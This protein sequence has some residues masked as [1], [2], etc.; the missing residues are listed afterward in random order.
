[1]M[2]DSFMNTL[3][4]DEMMEITLA[5]NYKV[6]IDFLEREIGLSP[7]IVGASTM[8]TAIK[9]AMEASGTGNGG[10]YMNVLR[11]SEK[12]RDR[13]I[14][15]LVVPETWFFRGRES[16]K[17][18]VDYAQKKWLAC[19]K[20]GKFR[21]LSFPCSTGEEA[22]TIAMMLMEKGFLPRNFTIDAMDISEKALEKAKTGI[23]SGASF[24]GK[25]QWFMDPYFE[26]TPEGFKVIKKLQKSVRFSKKNILNS[27]TFPRSDL[28][29]AVFCRNLIIYMT[30]E[31]RKRSVDL[32]EQVLRQDGVVFFGHSESSAFKRAGFEKILEPKVFACRKIS[33]TRKTTAPEKNKF[34]TLNIPDLTISKRRE[35]G[36]LNTKTVPASRPTVPPAAFQSLQPLKVIDRPVP[37][38]IPTGE[39]VNDDL[40]EVA[41]HLADQGQF[42]KAHNLCSRF[43][44]KTPLSASAYFL[45]G[46][47][48]QALNR[49]VE[50][51]NCFQKAVYLDPFHALALE[52]LASLKESRD[53][54]AEAAQLRVR[55][56]RARALVASKAP[57]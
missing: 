43:L 55:A 49:E 52:Y 47:I 40:L 53:K 37:E 2:Q 29:D 54:C 5:G 28:Y 20:K 25:D 7:D 14:E 12:E 51:E 41:R 56:Q 48:C 8:I 19:M 13:L 18:L 17:F 33:K 32:I 34:L 57:E 15:M 6:I 27:D 1:M 10:E 3:T 50:S 38:N 46:V 26:H 11:S 22:Y 9:R 45:K 21:V 30:P 24:R 23:Y 4:G 36:I 39:E 16:F 42:E 44:K 35:S 31:A